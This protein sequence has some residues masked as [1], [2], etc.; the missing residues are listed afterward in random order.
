MRRSRTSRDPSLWLP[1]VVALVFLSSAPALLSACT[2]A[3]PG[4]PEQELERADAVFSG[5]VEAIEPAPMPED[6][7]QW[8]SRLEVS[9]RLLA[10]W[11]GVPEGDRVTVSTASQSAA[12]GFGFEKGK[13]YLVYAYDSGEMLTATLCSRTALLKQA[14]Q[15]LAGLGSP[16]RQ[17]D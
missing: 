6:H 8:P 10:V 2:C 16:V 5:K 11:K 7:P 13:K 15:D 9:L 17:P 1:A 4:P 3:P 12:C 14:D